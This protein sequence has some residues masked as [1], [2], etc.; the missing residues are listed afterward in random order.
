MERVA[1]LDDASGRR[2]S[3]LLNP[4]SLVLRRQAGV[5]SRDTAGGL[6]SGHGLSDDPLFFTGGGIT[7]I[8]IDLLFDVDL[9]P[10]PVSTPTRSR[11][12]RDLTGPLWD[13]SEN[14]RRQDAFGSLPTVRFF[15]G[16]W[17]MPGVVVA[18]AERLT[19]FDSDGIPRR[20]W[21]RMRLRR[22]NAVERAEPD[23]AIDAPGLPAHDTLPGLLD[24]NGLA[25]QVYEI[26]GAQAGADGAGPPIAERPDQIAYRFYGNPALGLPLCLF[27]NIL[28]PL[29]VEPG[30]LIELPS[31]EDLEERP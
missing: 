19:Q 16:K 8:E 9:D 5:R 24:D 7:E 22:V 4:E 14:G 2:I 17:Q 26:S 25:P 1:F 12:V 29:R 21:L 31:L 20:S 11:D 3:C 10:Q 28:D 13:L 30:Q 6:A 23:I 27:N 18:V 15:W